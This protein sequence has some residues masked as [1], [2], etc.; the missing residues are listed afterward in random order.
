VATA[1]TTAVVLGLAL[2]APLND[3]AE[4]TSRLTL[5]VFAVVNTS[6]IRIKQRAGQMPPGIYQAPSWVPWAGAA[7]CIVLLAADAAMKL[8]A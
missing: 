1:V 3:L 8:L 5:F 6:L 7:T 2:M 4:A